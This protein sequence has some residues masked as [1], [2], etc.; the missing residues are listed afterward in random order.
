MPGK[1]KVT[2]I[3]TPPNSFS[4]SGTEA[5]VL[6]RGENGRRIVERGRRNPAGERLDEPEGEKACIIE[7][8]F[9]SAPTNSRRKELSKGELR[10]GFDFPSKG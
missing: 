2:P 3:D 4:K 10:R 9:F 6:S 8:S 5:G 1:K 7:V